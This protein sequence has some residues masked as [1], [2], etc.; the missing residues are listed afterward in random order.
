MG[1]G[2]VRHAAKPRASTQSATGFEA[3][4]RYHSS[5]QP[6]IAYSHDIQ[7]I[8]TYTFRKAPEGASSI[9]TKIGETDMALMD[10]EYTSPKRPQTLRKKPVLPIVFYCSIS[11]VTS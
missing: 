1:Q 7:Y 10:S 11:T 5:S 6:S 4:A 2:R 3:K 8:F 9:L